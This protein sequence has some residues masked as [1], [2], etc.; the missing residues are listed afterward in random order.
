VATA[1][2]KRGRVFSV[3]KNGPRFIGERRMGFMHAHKDGAPVLKTESSWHTIN[4]VYLNTRWGWV[5]VLF[6]RRGEW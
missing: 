3:I 4:G 2:R 6:R 1:R 5:S